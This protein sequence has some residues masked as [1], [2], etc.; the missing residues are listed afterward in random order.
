MVNQHQLIWS[1]LQKPWASM[2]KL[3][4]LITV[5]YRGRGFGGSNPPPP[6]IPKILQNRAKLNLIVEIVKN[7]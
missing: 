4:G 5:A 3:T 1:E 6:E 7:C 2:S